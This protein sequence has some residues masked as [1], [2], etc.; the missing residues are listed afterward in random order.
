MKDR[1]GLGGKGVGLRVAKGWRILKMLIFHWF[2]KVF[3]KINFHH[4]FGV[5]GRPWGHLG[6]LLGALGGSL[7]VLGALLGALGG[8]LGFPRGTWIRIWD[9]F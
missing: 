1:G 6:C 7:G 2:Y 8:S 9:L 5:L 4:F 3:W